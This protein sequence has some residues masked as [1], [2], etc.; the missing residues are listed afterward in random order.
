M[1]YSQYGVEDL[2]QDEFFRRWVT[3]GDAE[4][5]AYWENWM[6]FHPKRAN[7]VEEA[8][9]IV[10]RY[11]FKKDQLN[12][13]ELYEL[14]EKVLNAINTEGKQARWHSRSNVRSVAAAIVLIISA[15][16]VYFLLNYPDTVTLT[17][18]GGQ[19]KEILLPDSTWITLNGN[20]HLEYRADWSLHEDREV[21][22]EGEAFFRVNRLTS[23]QPLKFV[24]HTQSLDIEVLGTTFNVNTR[25]KATKVMLTE[26][27][28]KLKLPVREH[29]YL[30]PGDLV[31]YSEKEIT[32]KRV[33]PDSYTA[34][35][36]KQLKLDNSPL[37]EVAQIIEDTYAVEVHLASKDLSKIAVSGTLPSDN[38]DI[39]LQAMTVSLDLR[40]RQEGQVITIQRR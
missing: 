35:K 6:K 27:K 13:V 8:R 33:N 7:M 34:W 30:Q 24:V 25:P 16:G 22:L 2:V 1:N 31:T 3:V 17:T 14:T 10:L 32:T 9:L 39:L 23:Q 11:D 40:I 12:E 38:L 19:I 37:A 28:V 21:W 20:S 26:G 5:C 36:E 4:A 18:N 29:L 15:A